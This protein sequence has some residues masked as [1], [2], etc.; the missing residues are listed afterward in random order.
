MF[1]STMN[2]RNGIP[3]SLP[4]L[5]GE[6]WIRWSKHMQSLFGFH[7]TLEVVTNGRPEL[8]HNANGVQR[9]VHK[10][11]KKKDCKVMLCIQYAVDA[12]NFD[13]ISHTESEKEACN[14]LFK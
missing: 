2:G 6:N 4:I 14:I 1:V 10:D 7:E 5:D 12:E 3:N 13:C 9:I 8:Y 11:D